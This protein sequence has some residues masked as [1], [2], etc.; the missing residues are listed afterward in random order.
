MQAFLFVSY[1][2]ALQTILTCD[3]YTAPSMDLQPEQP[4]AED[5]NSILKRKRKIRE[6]KGKDGAFSTRSTADFPR[7]PPSS[8]QSLNYL[9]HCTIPRWGND[10]TSKTVDTCRLSSPG[11]FASIVELWWI[12]CSLLVQSPSPRLLQP[13]NSMLDS[14]LPM[15]KTQSQMRLPG[16][17][18]DLC[19]EKPC[20]SLHLQPSEQAPRVCHQHFRRRPPEEPRLFHARP[21]R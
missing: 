15:S 21:S 4:A 14:M 9:C 1:S 19:R 10:A 7:A 8:N 20:R 16:P 6:H 13:A 11:R 3:H 2:L 17:M 18:Q 12:R 5:I